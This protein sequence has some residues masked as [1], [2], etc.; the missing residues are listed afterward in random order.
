[1]AKRTGI[2]LERVQHH[3]P[4]NQ[5]CGLRQTGYRRKEIPAAMCAYD[6]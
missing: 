1:M 2:P 6:D 3:I 5:S 4:Q